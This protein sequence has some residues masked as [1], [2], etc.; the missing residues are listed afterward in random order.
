MFFGCKEFE[1]K[2]LE[3]WNV[4]NVTN[5]RNM[6]AE[7]KKLNC[8]LSNWDVSNVTDMG[9][10]FASCEK[11]DCNLSNWD[12]SNVIY[13]KGIFYKCPIKN[14]YKPKFKK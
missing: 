5:M 2:G 13:M 3:N 14:K 12:V 4:S 6:F 7:C 11:L 10:M 9:Y 8:N 1:G